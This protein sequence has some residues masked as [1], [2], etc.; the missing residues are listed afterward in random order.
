MKSLSELGCRVSI[1]DF[2]T[3]FS[4]LQFLVQRK[5][6]VREI[7][8]DRSFV[9]ALVNGS[10]SEFALVQAIVS[11]AHGTGCQVVAEGV[12]LAESVPLLRAMGCDIAQGFYFGR[13]MPMSAVLPWFEAW[14]RAWAL[15][16]PAETAPV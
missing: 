3:G 5:D 16:A 6:T 7:K 12:E 2:G 14:P 13:P 1:D 11:M 4:S 8:I 15:V 10:G 9:G